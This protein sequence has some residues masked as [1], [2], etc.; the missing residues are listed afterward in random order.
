MVSNIR[1]SPSGER[2]RYIPCWQRPVRRCVCRALRRA[3][4]EGTPAVRSGNAISCPPVGI[5]AHGMSARHGAPVHVATRGAAAFVCA[6][7]AVAVARAR[8]EFRPRAVPYAEAPAARAVAASSDDARA[9]T[10]HAHAHP[11]KRSRPSSKRQ[12]R[13]V[14][15][16]ESPRVTYVAACLFCHGVAQAEETPVHQ[17]GNGNVGGTL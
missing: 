15:G 4:A 7:P 5:N 6:A 3:K 13:P 11:A 14:R 16:E 2:Y 12:R 17:N 10:S 8:R 9:D 1:Y